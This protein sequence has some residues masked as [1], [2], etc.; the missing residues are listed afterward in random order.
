MCFCIDC[1]KKRGDDEV[2]ERGGR[3]YELP[4]LYSAYTIKKFDSDREA[5]KICSNWV[6]SYH[7][8]TLA[9]MEMIAKDGFV[10]KK[11][12]EKTWDGKV[13][14]M[15]TDDRRIIKPHNRENDYTGET[16]WFDP[17]QVFTTPS[18]RYAERYVAQKDVDKGFCVLLQCRQKPDSFKIGP[19]SIGAFDDNE[20]ICP[21]FH[22]KELEFM[23]TENL[24]SLI[25]TRVLIR[26]LN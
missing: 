7:A 5:Q 23:T 4:L 11:P 3:P 14:Q 2:Y 13:I 26:Y 20:K 17:V 24:T 10:L 9:N 8:T 19:E 15:R 16:F 12:G 1:H 6:N 21:T 18:L 25:V 22:N